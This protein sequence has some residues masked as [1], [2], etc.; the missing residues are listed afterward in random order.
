MML[1]LQS[2]KNGFLHRHGRCRLLGISAET[3]LKY[4]ESQISPNGS[5]V[6]VGSPLRKPLY[7]GSSLACQIFCTFYSEWI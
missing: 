2:L 5:S 6:D 4:S 1:F 3:T 7:Q